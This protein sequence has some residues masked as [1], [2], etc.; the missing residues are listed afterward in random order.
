MIMQS[1]IKTHL[2]GRHTAVEMMRTKA[3]CM[4]SDRVCSVLLPDAGSLPLCCDL[5]DIAPS[6]HLLFAV[7]GLVLLQSC[8]LPLCIAPQLYDLTLA[9]QT[10]LPVMA[11]RNAKSAGAI[12]R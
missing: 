4:T 1:A 10:P 6:A 9:C 8:V 12:C 11:P 3:V 2:V 7:H 5:I